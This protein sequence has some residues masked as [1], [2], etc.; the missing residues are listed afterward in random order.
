[1]HRDPDADPRPASP[2]APVYVSVEDAILDVRVR[3]GDVI[4]DRYQRGNPLSW[5]IARIGRSIYSHARL[6]SRDGADWRTLDTF[7]GTGGRDLSL[8]EEV[9]RKP[10]RL[11]VYRCT[12][13]EYHRHKAARVMREIVGRQYGW[14]S[15]WWCALRHA[16]LVR[17]LVSPR[18]DD[19]LNGGLVPFCS[20]AV[21]AA[22]RTAGC[23]PVP[24]LP[25][26]LT[27]PGDLARSAVL[28]YQFTL[29]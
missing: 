5:A 25:D 29:E 26:R 2:A 1:M 20:Q 11:D 7:Q 19:N 21:A 28:E 18:M 3:V 14:R 10:R 17:L 9:A 24:N 16:P 23:D 6:L 13:L 22:M 12:S 8:S 27:E 15:L 4:L